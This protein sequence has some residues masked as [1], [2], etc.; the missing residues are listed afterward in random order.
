MGS[1][2]DPNGCDMH[3]QDMLRAEKSYLCVV[4]ILSFHILFNFY[5]CSADNKNIKQDTARLKT[6]LSYE[7]FNLSWLTFI[8][9]FPD[10]PSLTLG[11]GDV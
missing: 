5:T 1:M 6:K 7:L 10:P 4:C 8:H 2:E 9:I 3:I 11:N